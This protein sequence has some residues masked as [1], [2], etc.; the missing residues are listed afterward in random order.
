VF[1]PYYFDHSTAEEV[2]KKEEEIERI[3]LSC[4]KLG[5]GGLGWELS[6]TPI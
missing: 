3:G 6:V 4:L 5:D 1:P 2:E